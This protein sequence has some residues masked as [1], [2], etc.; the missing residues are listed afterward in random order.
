MKLTRQLAGIHE[1]LITIVKED[2]R[3]TEQVLQVLVELTP[4]SGEGNTE[5]G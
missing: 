1:Q 3:I 4:L 5:N 2:D